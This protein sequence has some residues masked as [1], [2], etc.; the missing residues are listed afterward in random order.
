MTVE[1]QGDGDG[2]S[3]CM[4]T[5]SDGDWQ[6]ARNGTERPSGISRGPSIMCQITAIDNDNMHGLPPF[7]LPI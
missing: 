7:C 5:F 3:L 1:A 6:A 2:V 4:L